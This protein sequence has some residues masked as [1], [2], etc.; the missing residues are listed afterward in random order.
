MAP[1]SGNFQ[2]SGKAKETTVVTVVIHKDSTR[3]IMWCNVIECGCAN[4]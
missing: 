1:I 3:G 4:T 2:T